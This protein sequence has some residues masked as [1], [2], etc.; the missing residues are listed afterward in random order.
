M[1]IDQ[2]ILY[3]NH[4]SNFDQTAFKNIYTQTGDNRRQIIQFQYLTMSDC[5][6]DEIENNM[7]VVKSTADDIYY[8][9]HNDCS[10]GRYYTIQPAGINPHQTT[11]L[12]SIVP[13]I[14]NTTIIA[15]IN[16]TI[17]ATEINE[18][19]ISTKQIENTTYSEIFET[20]DENMETANSDLS[21]EF[22]CLSFTESVEEDLNINGMQGEYEKNNK[23]M[24]FWT[25]VNDEENKYD[26]FYAE[27][28]N[29]W[30]IGSIDNGNNN[31]FCNIDIKYMNSPIECNKWFDYNYNEINYI[32][33]NN[34]KCAING[35]SNDSNSDM[36]IVIVAFVLGFFIIIIVAVI[37][38]R[39]SHNKI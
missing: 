29:N 21:P 39:I 4:R 34:G 30:E 8:F 35:A 28:S 37:Y 6:Y 5:I 3:E 13:T 9:I 12:P 2:C 33:L 7:N 31:L 38:W 11:S 14:T 24:L 15:T 17:I 32:I 16:T 10:N 22:I 25:K 23:F 36:I 27:L 1:I 20:T 18:T 19:I 26:I